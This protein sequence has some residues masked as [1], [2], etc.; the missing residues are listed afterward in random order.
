MESICSTTADYRD[1]YY[2]LRGSVIEQ[3]DDL[4][5]MPGRPALITTGLIDPLRCLWGLVPTRYDKQ[6]YQRPVVDLSR[7]DKGMRSWATSRLVPKLLVATQGKMPEVLVDESG[8]YL[9]CVPVITVRT[10]DGGPGL[11]E[12]AAIFM[13][14]AA[15]DYLRAAKLGAGLSADAI[16]VSAADLREMPAPVKLEPLREAATLLPKLQSEGARQRFS[17]LTD[18]AFEVR[19]SDHSA[20]D[21]VFTSYCR[22][23][24]AV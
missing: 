22:R 3:E 4:D 16:K 9:P 24:V 18:E 13:S 19:P 1:Q 7:L 2:G 14:P 20:W 5:A 17:T 12:L 21:A 8:E 11:M 23:R 6:K 10:L 15:F